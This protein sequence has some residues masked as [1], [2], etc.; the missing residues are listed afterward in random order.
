MLDRIDKDLLPVVE[1]I[2]TFDLSDEV[3]P[4]AREGMEQM[5]ALAPVPTDSGVTW[6]EGHIATAA[7]HDLKVVIYTPDAMTG[8]LPALLHIHGGGYVAGSHKISH[9]G[10]IGLAADLAAVIVSVDYR[11]APETVAPGSVEDCY[12][13]L[14]WMVEQASALGIDT[15]RIAVRGESAGGGL[16]AALALLARD[17]GGPALVHQNLIYPM[18]DDLTCI[19]E[20]PEHLGAFVWTAASNRYGW[21]SLLGKAPGSADVSPYCAPARATDLAGLPSSFIGVGE[22]DLFLPEDMDYARRLILAGVRTEMHVYPG[23]FHGFDAQADA[24][25]TIAMKRDA[26]EALRRALSG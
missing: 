12:A 16:A 8:E 3:L 19:T 20:L 2:P 5:A 13:A 26:T 17:R 25:V 15:T 6:R 9:I 4:M 24:P 14:C 23:A 18:L 7:G 22:L 10:N 1:A 21:R 11:L